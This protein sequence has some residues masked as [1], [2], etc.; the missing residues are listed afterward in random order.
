MGTLRRYRM[1]VVVTQNQLLSPHQVCQTC[2]LADRQGQP[3]WQQ[4]RLR[5]GDLIRN[6]NDHQPEQYQCRMG[7]RIAHIR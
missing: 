3:R 1:L 4:G 2:L 5:C 6:L 7:F